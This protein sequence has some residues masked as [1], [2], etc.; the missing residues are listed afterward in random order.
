MAGRANSTLICACP[1]NVPS[2]VSGPNSNM[3]MKPAMTG[4][5]ANGRS[6]TPLTRLRPQN[7]CLASTIAVMVPKITFSTNTIRA[8]SAVSVNPCNASGLE[9]SAQNAASPSLKLWLAI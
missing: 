9:I 6:M 5:T 3:S 8:I 1:K 7:F 2:T 4:E